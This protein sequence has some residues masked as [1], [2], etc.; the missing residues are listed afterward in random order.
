MSRSHCT[1]RTSC[2]VD[3]VMCFFAV[4]PWLSRRGR[5]AARQDTRAA[6]HLLHAVRSRAT[7]PGRHGKSL[8]HMQLAGAD[9]CAG[10][11]RAPRPW[12]ARPEPLSTTWDPPRRNRIGRTL[13]LPDNMAH[14]P[15]A[16]HVVYQMFADMCCRSSGT[17]SCVCLL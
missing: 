5:V 10:T 4:E 13:R 3:E 11:L 14:H 1:W 15:W 9:C 2:V 16:V 7:R 8:L 12:A 17:T 6:R